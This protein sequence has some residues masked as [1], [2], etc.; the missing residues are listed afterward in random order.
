MHLCFYSEAQITNNSGS[1]NT[2]TDSNLPI[3]IINTNGQTI[4]NNP[5]IIVD[6]SII[7]N[8]PGLRN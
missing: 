4:I 3:I 5:K 6:M 7:N 2:F 1:A 8:G